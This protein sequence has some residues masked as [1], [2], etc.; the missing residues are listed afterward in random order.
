LF[1]KD[2]TNNG[3]AEGINM[4]IENKESAENFEK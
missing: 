4:R 2:I 3:N 1:G